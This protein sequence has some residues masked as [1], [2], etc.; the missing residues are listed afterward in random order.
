MIKRMDEGNKLYDVMPENKSRPP[1]SE[2]LTRNAMV[3]ALVL[4]F[5]MALSVGS[6]G[7][8]LLTAVKQSLDEDW[9]EQLGKLTFVSAMMPD[10]MQVFFPSPVDTLVAPCF[11]TIVHAWSEDE[12]Y[13][14]YGVH[15][16]KVYPAMSG[17]VIGIGHG[18]GEERVLKLSHDNGLETVY[19]NLLLTSVAVGDAVT[20]DSP[21]GEVLPSSAV[22][23]EV[24]RDGIAIDPTSLLRP[25]ETL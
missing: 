18:D 1:F 3:G 4:L 5:V 16:K 23:F 11:G 9:D 20:V 6:T 8:S 24:R 13:V 14:G 2:R 25:R 22:L 10:A 7:N 19:Y 15:E 21:L 12:P 17:E